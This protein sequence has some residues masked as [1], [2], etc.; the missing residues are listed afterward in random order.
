MSVLTHVVLN[1]SS[2]RAEPIATQSLAHI[3]NAH[4]DIARAFVGLL[5]LVNIEFEP[6]HIEAEIE[7]EGNQP[8]LTIKDDHGEVRVLV[9]NKFW[10][11][12]TEAQ[13]VAYLGHLSE[14]DSGGLLFIVPEQRVLTVWN[15]LKLRCREANL[16]CENGKDNGPIIWSSVDCNKSM[17]ITNWS[18]VLNV[19]LTAA[20]F[21]G[22]GRVCNDILQLQDLANRMD[23]ESFLPIRSEELT[24][25][26]TAHRLINYSALIED[27]TQKLKDSG[28]ADTNK[29]MP[30]HGWYSHGRYLRVH[31]KFGLWLGVDFQVW[32]K[33][34]ITPLWWRIDDGEFSGVAGRFHLVKEVFDN[35]DYYETTGNLYFPIR[36]KTGVERN[37]VIQDAAAQMTRMADMLL[38]NF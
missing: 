19:L 1:N 10:A 2:L 14:D 18:H 15:E 35:E 31:N 4:P 5:S 30:T 28:L 11:G 17:L 33:T 6:V 24:D 16:E 21:G 13:P 7:H 3:L 8:D 9:E 20:H 37:R 32:R 36:L 22:H 38:N 29:L 23:L 26:E 25:Q 34:G 12:F 27:I